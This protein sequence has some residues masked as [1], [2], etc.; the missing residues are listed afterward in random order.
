MGVSNLIFGDEFVSAIKRLVIFGA[1]SAIAREIARAAASEQVEL[2]LISRQAHELSLMQRDL[3][4][5]GSPHVHTIV[6]DA[7][8]INA[9]AALLER[10][11]KSFADFDAVLVA[12]GELTPMPQAEQDLEIF[13]SSMR[14]NF[15]GVATLLLRLA[16]YF[17]QRGRGCIAAIGSVAGDRGRRVN[18]LYASAKAG[19]DTFLSGLRGRMAQC[20]VRVVS[21]KPG[22][23]DTPMTAGFKKG[24]LFAAPDQVGR[25]AWRA[26]KTRN[27]A[28]YLP[29][30][31]RPIMLI[32]RALPEVIFQRLKF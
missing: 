29:W 1:S 12:N 20:G 22:F 9:Q 30:F 11:S 26:I 2:C 5:R 19:L 21:I 3:E 13:F 28:V 23:V 17:E 4:V 8:E 31:W 18:Y 27:R 32:I 7:T 14:I 25:A 16:P 15:G 24:A 6:S 10:I